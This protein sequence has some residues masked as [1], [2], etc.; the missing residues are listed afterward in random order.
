MGWVFDEEKAT[1]ITVRPVEGGVIEEG[2][3]EYPP[4]PPEPWW[5]K[6]LPWAVIGGFLA[7][8]GLK[9]EEMK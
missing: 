7:L 2:R 3:E 9:E 5:K 6:I 8:I 4:K 1:T